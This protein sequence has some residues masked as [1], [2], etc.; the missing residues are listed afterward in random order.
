MGA[1]AN[2]YHMSFQDESIR[3]R[4][5]ATHLLVKGYVTVAREEEARAFRDAGCE[6]SLDYDERPGWAYRVTCDGARPCY[7]NEDLYGKEEG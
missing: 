3:T 6:V 5:D 2:V 1:L 4:R 7:T